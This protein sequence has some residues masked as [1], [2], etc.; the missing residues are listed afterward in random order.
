MTWLLLERD[1]IGIELPCGPQNYEEPIVERKPEMEFKYRK[2]PKDNLL[3]EGTKDLKLY[4]ETWPQKL[5]DAH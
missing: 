5:L 2:V 4:L 1:K 3:E